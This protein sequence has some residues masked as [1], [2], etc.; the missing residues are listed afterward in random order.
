[1]CFILFFL[2]CCVVCPLWPKYGWE[3]A[4]AGGW[5]VG[6]Q[7]RIMF[8]WA[9]PKGRPQKP[10]WDENPCRFFLLV[11]PKISPSGILIK[12]SVL[13]RAGVCCCCCCYGD[14]D[15]L[16]HILEEPRGFEGQLWGW[17][18]VKG[19]ENLMFF[20]CLD[21]VWGHENGTVDLCRKCKS[22]IATSWDVKMFSKKWFNKVWY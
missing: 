13:C 17:R 5:P 8:V 12:L 19:L 16:C 11:L 10:R 7:R 3:G 22:T 15:L 20:V 2:S 18:W 6:G 9:A 21:L 4:S 14:K 1:M